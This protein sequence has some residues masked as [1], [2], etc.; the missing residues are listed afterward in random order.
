MLATLGEPPAGEGRAVEMKWDGQRAV[1]DT[2][3]GGVR[4]FSRN[5]NDITGAF[6]E[7]TGP[8]GEAV[9]D[10]DVVLDSKGRP[11]FSRLQR[12]MHVAGPRVQLRNDFPVT[13]YV[14]DV[15]ALDGP[16]RRSG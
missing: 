15:L 11:S 14:C 9:D 1:T 12:K 7:L 6:P 10:H 13:Y 5:G 3:S 2:H 4:L 16:D 8:I